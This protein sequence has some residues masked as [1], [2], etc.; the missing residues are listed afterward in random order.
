[1]PIPQWN[2]KKLRPGDTTREP[3]QGEFFAS[4]AIGS[5]ADA[6]VR[7]GFQNILDA[8]V[9]GQPA[10]VRVTIS[11]T[12]AAV[13]PAKVTPYL[14]GLWPHITAKGNGLAEAPAESDPCLYLAFEDFGTTG[15]EGDPAQ[16]RKE[17][18]V[19]NGFFNFF[20]AE[21]HS[22]KEETDRGRW[23]VG[24]TVF[25]RASR[26]NT[27]WAVTVRASDG[28]R[29]LMG[30]TILKSHPLGPTLYVP[31]G[32]FGTGDPEQLT[33]PVED[34]KTIDG[35]CKLF[36]LTR[37]D[38]PGLSI[39]VAWYDPEDITV[40]T[41]IQAVV[42]GY[43]VPIL[44]GE[45]T[46]TIVGPDGA[47]RALAAGSLLAVVKAI[48]GTL[49]EEMVPVIELAAWA[50]TEGQSDIPTLGRVAAAGALR[51]SS[52]L[53]A[54]ERVAEIRGKLQ[55]GD[56]IALRVPMPVRP[57]KKPV[58]WSHFDVFLARDGSE[59]RG[60]P[61]FVREGIIIP[62]VRGRPTRGIRSLVVVEDK[63]LATML[64]DAENP[65]HTQW[66]KE[67]SN[68]KDKYLYG[69]S[70]IEFVRNSV[71][72]VVRL[73]T[74][75]EREADPAVLVDLFS[76]PAEPQTPNTVKA[77][78]KKPRP[79]PG[80][81]PPEPGRPGLGHVNTC[82]SSASA[83]ESHTRDYPDCS[84]ALGAPWRPADPR[85]GDRCL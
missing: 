64:G 40:E 55:A 36:N 61:L 33:L 28:K 2:F 58:E 73:A 48:G 21:G 74:E 53:L 1:M 80:G 39:V 50:R 75:T 7:E 18:G 34:A 38:R 35:F 44:A 83:D 25:P 81:V 62:D 72:E 52:D 4:E 82:D 77:K 23:G 3:I 71:A 15:L 19:K 67:C 57:K 14:A 56:N 84:E 46:V 27:F 59:Q 76:L 17:E 51:W 60:R 9:N 65:S 69:P 32:Y 12:Q 63:P 13:A 5:S 85:C 16:W 70:N 43:F 10:H 47:E 26:I 41:I 29:L 22:D 78:G 24:K 8:R 49:A 45:L 79:E 31:D 11:G 68:Y 66:Q 54:P 20:R 6:L 37:Q 30:R 42:E